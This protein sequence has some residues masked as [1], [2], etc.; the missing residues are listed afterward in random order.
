MWDLFSSTAVRIQQPDCY[1]MHLWGANYSGLKQGASGAPATTAGSVRV[2]ARTGVELAGRCDALI[3]S[4]HTGT[5]WVSESSLGTLPTS[6]SQFSFLY[7]LYS[8]PS[9]LS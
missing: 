4:D 3:S 5:G 2:A 6:S 1:F 8:T 9:L 7:S